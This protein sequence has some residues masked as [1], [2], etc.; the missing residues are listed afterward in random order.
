MRLFCIYIDKQV[1]DTFS[2]V[3]TGNSNLFLHYKC[4]IK[5]EVLKAQE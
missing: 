1:V 3:R 5:G 4:K 2:L